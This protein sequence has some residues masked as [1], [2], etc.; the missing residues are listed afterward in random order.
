MARLPL[1][2]LDS[3]TLRNL[4]LPVWNAVRVYMGFAL[5]LPTI[6]I[7]LHYSPWIEQNIS[8]LIIQLES[9]HGL[10]NALMAPMGLTVIRILQVLGYVGVFCFLGGIVGPH[11]A[12][13]AVVLIV[14]AIFYLAYRLSYLENLTADVPSSFLAAPVFAL[15]GF[16]GA[17]APYLLG[18]FAR[19]LLVVLSLPALPTP[20]E[21]PVRRNRPRP[22]G[23]SIFLKR[24]STDN[25]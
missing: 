1:P 8:H 5:G 2:R 22:K 10:L 15:Q 6:F 7:A 3:A 9:L 23:T 18:R 11:R 12:R 17:I 20:E 21:E 16:L 19:Q 4:L 24:S 25:A 13:F 14:A